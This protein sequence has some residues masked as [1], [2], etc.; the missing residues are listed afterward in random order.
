MTGSGAY[1]LADVLRADRARLQPLIPDSPATV[2]LRRPCQA[3]KDLV[4]HRVAVGNQLRARPAMPTLVD[5][6]ELARRKNRRTR[7]RS[8]REFRAQYLTAE[9]KE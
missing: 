3:R 7:S 1:A 9:N 5:E 4:A 6:D 2:A 8:D